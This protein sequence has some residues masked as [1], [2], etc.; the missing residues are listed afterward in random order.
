[1]S[2][3]FGSHTVLGGVA[4]EPARVGRPNEHLDLLPE[5]TKRPHLRSGA[6]LAWTKDHTK[7]TVANLKGSPV[8]VR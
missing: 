7:P 5:A 3:D 6:T 4:L 8:R 1:M 2:R